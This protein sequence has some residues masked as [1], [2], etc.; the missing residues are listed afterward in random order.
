MGPALET[1]EEDFWVW[2]VGSV[3]FDAVFLSIANVSASGW[4]WRVSLS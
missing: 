2:V 3:C 1:R 4:M